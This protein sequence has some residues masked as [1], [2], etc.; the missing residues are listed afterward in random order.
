MIYNDLCGEKVSA[1]GYGGM[2]F[3][4]TPEGKIDEVK[5]SHVLDIAIKN[6]IN[7][8]DT[9]YVYHFKDSERFM[10]E[11]LKKYDRSSIF[12]ATKYNY[13]ANPDYKQ[14]FEEQLSKMQTDYFDFYLVHCL[15]EKNVEEYL[16]CGCIEYF[17][18]QR[19]LGRIKHLGFSSHASVPT[20]D[21]FLKSNNWDFVQLQINYLDYI[22]DKTKAEYETVLP[23]NLPII[24]MEPLKGGKLTNLGEENNS[25]LKNI[26]SDWSIPTWGFKWVKNLPNIKL[27]LSG[28]TY[29]DQIEDNAKTF[30]DPS[31][32]TDSEVKTLFDV[33]SDFKSTLAVGCT[34]CEYCLSECPMKLN[35]P[36]ILEHY[37]RFKYTGVIYKMQHMNN[38]PDSENPARCIA[39]GKCTKVCPQ[40]I[41]IPK[42]LKDF[43]GLL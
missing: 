21:R 9:A 22:F 23:T 26:H 7:Y 14:A 11:A 41:D 5:A 36:K 31:K 38:L 42:H 17:N 30:S 1:L 19:R 28:M 13:F 10:G 37:N 33:A 18:E 34:K 39:C 6:G 12:Y 20:L 4:T 2:R 3:P 32:L 8:F 35:I 27:V 25:T 40:H 29:P 15:M 43:A 24:V 16:S